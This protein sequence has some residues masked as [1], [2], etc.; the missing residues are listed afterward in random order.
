M[1]SLLHVALALALTLGAVPGA[2]AQAAKPVTLIGQVRAALNEKD[3]AKAE[4]IVS[5]ERKARGDTAEVLAA[6][7]WIARGAQTLGNKA[8]A[9]QV[10]TEVQALAVK[11]LAGRSADEDANLATAIGA[12]IEVQALLGVDRGERS[13]VIAFLERELETY[14][15]TA[16]AKRIQKNINLLTL[17]G[18]PA[19]A[20][21]RAEWIGATAPAPLSALTGRIVVLFFWAHWCPDCKVQG[22]ILE[23]VYDK[24]RDQG[25]TIVA[26]TMRFGYVAGGKP[27][28]PDEELKYIVG[29]RDQYYGWMTKLPTPVSSAS[30]QRY[31]V[32]STPTIAIIDREGIIRTYNPGRMTEAELEA[33]IA[34][35]LP[36]SR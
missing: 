9:E 19:P 31:G 5:A 32:S 4:A 36:T 25:L 29:V 3:L 18:R 2:A 27:A 35:L 10:A 6:F 13:S 15:H 24:Y 11:A 33:R 22:P 7:S 20:L 12:A 23:K 21:E 17:E 8:R 16:L 34:A 28:P 14:R 1:R 30:H 26:P